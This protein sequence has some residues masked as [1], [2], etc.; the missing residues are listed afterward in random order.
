MERSRYCEFRVAGSS[1]PGSVA[2]ALAKNIQEGQ[3]VAL[4][5]VGAASVNQ[6]VKAIAIARGFM[7]P[8]GYNLSCIPAF[9]DIDI[10][11]EQKTAMFLQVRVDN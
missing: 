5:C 11:G 4:V 10:A 3:I 1:N 6:G 2:G 8:Q 9:R 7:G